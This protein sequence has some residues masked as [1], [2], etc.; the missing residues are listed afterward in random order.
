MAVDPL[1]HILTLLIAERDKL[2]RAIEALG[3]P[4]KRGP[5]R[6]RKDATA[7]PSLSPAP[8]PAKKVGKKRNFSPEQR[9]AARQ[10]MKQMWA[11]RRKA[12]KAA[13]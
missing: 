2:N 11:K 10:R 12:A 4:G 8:A 1:D 3:A 5:G 13:G 7:T 9:E 6:P